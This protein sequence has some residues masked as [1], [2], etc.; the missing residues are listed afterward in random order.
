MSDIGRTIDLIVR[1]SLAPRLKAEG[2]KKRARTFTQESQ[3]HVKVVN[4]QP[5]K[6]NQG[7]EGSFTLNLG[8]YFPAVADA[9]DWFPIKTY[10]KEHDCTIRER[11]GMLMPGGCD[12]W[13]QISPKSN[14]ERI[15]AEVLE[16]WTTYG[17]PW[18]SQ[19]SDMN[20]AKLALIRKKDYFQA[21]GIALVQGD[22]KE[23]AELLQKAIQER[24]L[25]KAKFYSWGKKNNL[26][27]TDAQLVNQGDGE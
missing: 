10:P 11:I 15:K 2:Y 12:K 23:A 1:D 6:W 14:L 25:A 18:I 22:K 4:V 20:E 26:L 13:W 27:E 3:D 16:A 17:N 21:A 19:V 8:I 5:S 7:T 9:I 24:P